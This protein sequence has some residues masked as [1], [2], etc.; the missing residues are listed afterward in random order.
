VDLDFEF[1]QKKCGKNLLSALNNLQYTSGFHFPHPKFSLRKNLIR[2]IQTRYFR[3]YYL[4][5]C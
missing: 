5:L 4:E 3:K 1:N 2:W